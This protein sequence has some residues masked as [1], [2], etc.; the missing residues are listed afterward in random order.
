M[1]PRLLGRRARLRGRAARA[2][3]SVLFNKG[4]PR[5]IVLGC[6][7]PNPATRRDSRR[8]PR[9]AASERR[10]RAQPAIGIAGARH[11]DNRPD[12]AHSTAARKPPRNGGSANVKIACWLGAAALAG[13]AAPAMAG[14]PYLTDDPIPTDLHHWEIYAFSTGEGFGSALA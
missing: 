5:R 14:P 10:T 11:C 8:F 7:H 2:R 6:L 1:G 4:Q 13:V 3:H 12:L 9:Q